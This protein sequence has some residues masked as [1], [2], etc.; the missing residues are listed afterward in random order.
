MDTSHSTGTS[1]LEATRVVEIARVLARHWRLS[2]VFFIASVSITLL[3]VWLAPRSYRSESKLYIRLG[4]ESASLDP[5]AMI[6]RP[7]TSGSPMPSGRENELNSITEILQSR[8]LLEQVVDVIGPQAIL[9]GTDIADTDPS[10]EPR[11]P[12]PALSSVPHSTKTANI[13]I[14]SDWRRAPSERDRAIIKL[15]EM[16][17][18]QAIKKSDVV[19]VACNTQSPRLAQ[20]VVAHLVDFYL[21]EHLRLNRTSGADEFLDRQTAEMRAK[22]VGAE[23]DLR[24][25]K[26]K[27]G[28]ASPEVQRGLMVT[29]AGRLEDELL[30]TAAALESSEAEMRQLRDQVATL[31]K[32][33]TTAH[34]A[35][36]PNHAPELMRNE[37]Y[38]LQMLEQELASKYT[39]KHFSVRQIRERV[40][41][42]KEVLAATDESH[43]QVT[44]GPN[45]V[46]EQSH[47]ALI[48]QEPLLFSLRAKADALRSQLA[49]VREQIKALNVDE[50]QIAQLTRDVK[51]H[52]TNYQAY[53][54]HL[55][56]NRIDQA[57]EAGRISSIN[58]IQPATFEPK[59][60]GPK[61]LII[62]GLGLAIAL[63]GTIGLPL[64]A[65]AFDLPLMNS[66]EVENHLGVDV[67]ASVPRFQAEQMSGNGKNW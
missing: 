6:G 66:Q 29:R 61:V 15:Q 49:E 1:I 39:D 19:R 34:M 58:I 43:E 24:K 65:D 57:L 9:L 56:Q 18:V 62:L 12:E 30:T 64:V 67:L 21:D 23:E 55:E 54:Q 51:W 46:Y 50:L 5:T 26:D 32:T 2:A 14:E 47:I 27:T 3:I 35:G 60:V 40:P 16:I 33:T 4:R 41:A 25:L 31:P 52:E 13:V 48:K 59:P 63:I 38:R 20:K 7:A 8:V 10:L 11:L 44:S 45:A 22:L 53:A 37:L 42:A 36:I 28:L 17:E